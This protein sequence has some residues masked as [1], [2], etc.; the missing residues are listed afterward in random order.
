MGPHNTAANAR[1][2]R[3]LLISYHFPPMNVISA[4]RVE[5]FARYLPEHGMEV[6]VLTTL[7]EPTPDG[8]MA[9]HDPATPM[10]DRTEGSIR[11]L[12][13]PRVRTTLQRL[14]DRCLRVPVLS[15]LTVFLCHGCGLF[16]LRIVHINLLYAKYLKEHVQ[17][18]SYDVVLCSSSPEEHIGLGAWVRRR[19]GA[20]FVADYRDLYD[21]RPLEQGPE[22]PV[23]ERIRLAIMHHYHRRWAKNMDL[24][25]SVSRPLVDTLARTLRVKATLEV[26]N[27][28]MSEPDS[29]PQS[30][31]DSTLF[32]VTYAGRIYAWQNVRPFME[33]FRLFIAELRTDEREL[34]DLHI[35][36]CQEP[37]KMRELQDDLGGLLTHI[38]LKRIPRE[39][40]YQRIRASSVLLVFDIGL[41]GGLTGKLMDYVGFRRNVLMI[42]TDRGV[43]AELIRSSGIGV[44][45]SDP[46]EAAVHLLQWFREW[47]RQGRPDFRG[48]ETIIEQGS[49]RSH[50]ATLA[51][52]IS[53]MVAEHRER[54]SSHR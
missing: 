27:G 2:I 38:T 28:H 21:T 5:G 45:A 30:A 7:W 16:N 26:R 19:T 18:E 34:V 47:Q 39:L 36:G 32:K 31:I 10:Q 37:E 46:A 50:S 24:L 1:P 54:T 43:M 13:V 8:D 49:R 52:A 41:R 35:L 29:S 6:T 53:S 17:K 15:Q 25:V 11:V 48:D 22:R 12:R 23:R 20:L 14:L 9:W 44:A 3:V 4:F 40:V 51:E 42:P 33:A